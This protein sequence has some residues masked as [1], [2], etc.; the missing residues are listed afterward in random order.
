MSVI[1]PDTLPA[2]LPERLTH[3][4][5][6]ERMA[7]PRRPLALV[8]G[9]HRAAAE[10]TPYRDAAVL[11]PMVEREAGLTV[12]LTRRTAHLRNH[13]GQIAFP[14]GR[15]E[16][17]DGTPAQTALRE[18]REE[19]GLAPDCLEVLG[20]LDDYTTGT[21]FRITPVVALVHQP[22]SLNP[23]PQEVEEVFE[24]PVD[25]LYRPAHRQ[26]NSIVNDG[27]LHHYHAIPYGRHYIWGAT[28]AMLVHLAHFLLEGRSIEPTPAA[29]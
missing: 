21:A 11:V 7:A 9:D 20:L 14:G 19:I 22:F 10:R 5:L 17:A 13:A 3:Q 28:A 18:T 27:R 4:W 23:D 6:R 25:L 24:L 15:R 8:D 2:G 12:L 16:E 26:R 29:A 1:L